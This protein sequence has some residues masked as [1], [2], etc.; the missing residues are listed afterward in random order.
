MK[1]FVSVILIVALM[2]VVFTGCGDTV[3]K[4]ADSVVEA[5]KEEL[6]AQV[7]ATIEEY[8]LEA[9]EVKATAG[10]LNDEGGSLQFYCAVLVKSNSEDSVKNAA[11][12]VGKLFSESGYMAQSGSSVE[13]DHLVKKTLTYKTTDFSDGNYYTIYVYTGDMS[14]QLPDITTET[15]QEA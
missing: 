9:V 14:I 2:A 7:K 4:I 13:S 3:S 15:T 1:R 6:E 8:K 10:K 12:A 11:N 5:A